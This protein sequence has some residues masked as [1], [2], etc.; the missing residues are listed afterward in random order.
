WPGEPAVGRTVAITLNNGITGTVTGVAGDV[1]LFDARTPARPAIYLSTA[2]FTSTVRDLVVR[3]DGEPGSIV[4]PLG[5]AVAE[6][7]PGLPLYA[8]ETMTDLVDRSLASDRFT[9]ALL[10][11]FALVALALAAV[12]IFGVLSGEIGLRR[13]EIGIRLALGSSTRAIVVLFLRHALGRASLGI[14][15]GSLL[16]LALSRGMT[17]MVFGVSAHDP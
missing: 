16:A 7:E 15:C 8:V 4:S 2:R 1:H 12:G 11:A 5:S 17:T 3:V 14:A 6:L 10:S 9:T 13:R